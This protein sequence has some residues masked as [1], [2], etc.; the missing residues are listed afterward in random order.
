MSFRAYQLYFLKKHDHRHSELIVKYNIGLNALLQQGIPELVFYSDL[1]GKPNFSDQFKKIIIRYK[2]VGY[3]MDMQNIVPL[4][5]HLDG[6]E[7][8][9]L[10]FN[11]LYDA[12]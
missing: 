7:S 10:Y 11:C 4:C 3:N 8:W 6:K 5:N 12:F 1:V 2:K 9:L